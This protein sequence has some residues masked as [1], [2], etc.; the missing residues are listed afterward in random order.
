[1]GEYAQILSLHH[2]H[3]IGGNA[4]GTEITGKVRIINGYG[5]G[6]VKLKGA[7]GV[8]VWRETVITTV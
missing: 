3:K 1:M 4:F 7:T 8:F 2:V 6:E 5:V